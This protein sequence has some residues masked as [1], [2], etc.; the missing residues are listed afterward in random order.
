MYSGGVPNWAC[1][2]DLSRAMAAP[3]LIARYVPPSNLAARAKNPATK[4]RR[5]DTVSPPQETKVPRD[6]A[7]DDV[8]SHFSKR[9]LAKAAWAKWACSRPRCAHHERASPPRLAASKASCAATYVRWSPSRETSSSRNTFVRSSSRFRRLPA[10]ARKP[11]LTPSAAAMTTTSRAQPKSS[12]AATR[13]LASLG[14][15]GA[16][17]R[18]SPSG[19]VNFASSSK[20]PRARNSSRACRTSA[21]GGGEAKSNVATLSMPSALSWRSGP[22]RSVRCISGGVKSGNRHES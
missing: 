20:A 12:M 7:S 4:A 2:E 11:T 9:G 3:P 1:T 16:V 21:A 5:G 15:H 13:A 19:L 8:W 18:R 22:V 10:L 17:A 14:S 6:D